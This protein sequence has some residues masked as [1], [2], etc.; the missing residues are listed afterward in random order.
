M[1]ELLFVNYRVEPELLVDLVPRHSKPD[2][3]IDSAGRETAFVSAVCFRVAEVSSS[4]LRLP[5]LSFE[6]VNYRAYIR[7]GEVPAVYFFDMKV[8][9]RAIAALTT[10]LRAPIQF[11][12]IV[13]TTGT[14]ETVGD[15][16]Y[17]FR[18]PGFEVRAV[19]PG[20]PDAASEDT[21]PDFITHRLVGYAGSEGNLYKIEVDH[22]MLGAISAR[23]ESARAPRLEQLGLLTPDESSRPSSALYV[24]EALFKTK[25]P[26]RER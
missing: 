5:R 4:L 22:P 6:Q 2:T 1:R 3:R 26:T 9:S 14:I 13:L 15:V 21:P 10:F 23:I 19:I 8:N 18:S 24:R 20:H 25:P 7:M 12:D 11:E 17:V 16:D